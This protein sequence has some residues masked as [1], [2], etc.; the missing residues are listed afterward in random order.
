MLTT[1][2]INRIFKKQVFCLFELSVI[3]AFVTSH[4]LVSRVGQ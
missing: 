1:G 3:I 2:I 4:M